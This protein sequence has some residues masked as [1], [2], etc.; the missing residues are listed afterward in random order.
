VNDNTV[1]G[2]LDDYVLTH[3]IKASS[4]DFYRRVVSALC[5]W[6]GR[7]LTAE[8]FTVDLVNRFLL[9]KQEAKLTSAY[10]RSL[11]NGLRALL[12]HAGR[13]GK[14]RPVRLVLD[15]P[16]CWTPEEVCRL[17]D[18]CPN[19]LWRQRLELAYYTGLSYCDLILV[20]RADIRDGVLH[21]HRQKTGE[22]VW[23][24]IPDSLLCRLP[25]SG[26][27]FGLDCSDEWFRRQFDK[28]VKA[29][30][31]AGTFKKLRKSAGTSVES[32]HPGAG[33]LFLANSRKVF[34]LHYL[35][36]KT[37]KPLSPEPLRGRR[38]GA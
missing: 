8:E 9:F 27:L 21:W 19:E 16:D 23:V 17:V 26:T 1:W 11:R 34:E 12:N 6:Y 28:I 35:A 31:L 30:G 25:E 36:R 24:P 5:T 7:G 14:L 3:E 38:P 20:T 2:L 13:S 4:A 32:R 10:R 29:A 15:D 18:A 37:F 22:P 33:H